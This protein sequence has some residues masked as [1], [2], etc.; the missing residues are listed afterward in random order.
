MP[1]IGSTRVL[2]VLVYFD[3]GRGFVFSLAVSLSPTSCLPLPR[4]VAFVRLTGCR[5]Q[6]SNKF[7][8]KN[9]TP[10]DT[11]CPWRGVEIFFKTKPSGGK[12]LPPATLVARV[13]SVEIFLQEGCLNFVLSA[14]PKQPLPQRKQPS[15]KGVN[16]KQGTTWEREGEKQAL[17]L[18]ALPPEG[19]LQFCARIAAVYRVPRRAVFPAETAPEKFFVYCFN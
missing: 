8:W 14:D 7:F 17:L 15:E 10:R 1:P 18:T 5:V 6:T 2:S 9:T 12:I 13:G 4:T 16:K 11:F 3:R 19:V